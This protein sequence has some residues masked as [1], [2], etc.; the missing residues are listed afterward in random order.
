MHNDN[1]VDDCLI[2]EEKS[3]YN[4]LQSV[5]KNRKRIS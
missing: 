1:D 4:T 3:T 2:D 5:D